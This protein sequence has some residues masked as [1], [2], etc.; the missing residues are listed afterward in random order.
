MSCVTL[1]VFTADPAVI[2]IFPVLVVASEFFGTLILTVVVPAVPLVG[3]KVIHELSVF[4]VQLTVEEIFMDADC[5]RAPIF[6]LDKSIITASGQSCVTVNVLRVAPD[7]KVRLAT[8]ASV[9]VLAVTFSLIVIG[10][11]L[12]P[13]DGLTVHQDWSL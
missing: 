12:T 13:P 11:F 3:L 10:T 2:V 7:F 8:R 9:D 6:I 1:T 5:A 4:I